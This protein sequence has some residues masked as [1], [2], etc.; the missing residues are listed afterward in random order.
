VTQ[1]PDLLG[2]LLD[3]AGDRIAVDLVVLVL[4][5]VLVHYGFLGRELLVDRG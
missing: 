1:L 5:Q 3:A 2:D 4:G